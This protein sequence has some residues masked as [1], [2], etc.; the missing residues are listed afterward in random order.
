LTHY[1]A[2]TVETSVDLLEKAVERISSCYRGK[3]IIRIT[4]CYHTLVKL[5]ELIADTSKT[6]E[7]EA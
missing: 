1:V 5:A 3:T 6:K 7:N 4:V 2:I